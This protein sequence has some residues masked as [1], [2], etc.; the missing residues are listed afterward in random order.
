MSFHTLE[1]ADASALG[2]LLFCAAFGAQ[3]THCDQYKALRAPRALAAVMQHVMGSGCTASPSHLRLHIIEG[4]TSAA[5]SHAANQVLAQELI[6]L[7]MLLE[8]V[9]WAK[10]VRCHEL[11]VFEGLSSQALSHSFYLRV[12]PSGVPDYDTSLGRLTTAECPAHTLRTR[13]LEAYPLAYISPIYTAQDGAC[14]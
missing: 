5:I 2:H 9:P 4:A 6:R 11:L 3:P 12:W 14:A 13:L 8:R 7:L 1:R 10:M